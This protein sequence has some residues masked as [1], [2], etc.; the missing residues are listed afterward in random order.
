MVSGDEVIM[1]EDPIEGQSWTIGVVFLVTVEVVLLS[2]AFMFFH[3][4]QLNEM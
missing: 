4:C 3:T 1:V 2:C